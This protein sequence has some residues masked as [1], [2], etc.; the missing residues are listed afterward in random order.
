MESLVKVTIKQFKALATVA[1]LGSF[2]KAADHLHVTQS[3]LSASILG[4][5]REM[6]VVLLDRTTRAVSLT[7]AGREF[8]RLATRI[9]SDIEYAIHAAKTVSSDA[10]GR[11]TIGV[12]PMAAAFLLPAAIMEF[13]ARYPDVTVVVRDLRPDEIASATTIGE[14]D[15]GLGF[16]DES[17]TPL[18]RS[19]LGSQSMVCICT[20]NH[21]LAA[22]PHVRWADLIE[23][24][25]ILVTR[26]NTV[27]RIINRIFAQ[28]DAQPTPAYEVYH[29]MTAVGLAAAGLGVAIGPLWF[30]GRIVGRDIITRE[31][32]EPSVPL[33]LALICHPERSFTPAMKAFTTFLREH[34]AAPPAN[35]EMSA[36]S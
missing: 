11:V 28:M 33:E 8:L 26:D 1:E 2:T 36:P 22:R 9:L 23:E 5:E 10:S 27:R 6:G 29:A 18:T 16:F 25:L 12:P 17:I 7:E 30:A 13:R 34:L 19:G 24:K 32:I 4:L 20:S 3:A 35:A 14:V 21:P 15:F 31:I